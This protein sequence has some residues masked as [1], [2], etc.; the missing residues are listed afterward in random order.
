MK[1]KTQ[2]IIN[3]LGLTFKIITGLMFGSGLM[4]LVM[5]AIMTLAADGEF[6]PADGSFAEI[7]PLLSFVLKHYVVFALS[8]VV[9]AAG[10]FF[11]SFQFVKLRR[12]ARNILEKFVW[13]L[14]GFVS[15]FTVFVFIFPPVNLSLVLKLMMAGSMAFWLAPVAILLWLLRKREVKEAFEKSF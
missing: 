14:G 12:W 10:L 15:C 11:T 9:V 4:G 3:G 2:R 7:S 8:Q 1:E 13:L 5:Y 6:P